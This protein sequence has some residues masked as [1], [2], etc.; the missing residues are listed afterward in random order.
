MSPNKVLSYGAF[1]FAL[2]KGYCNEKRA[3]LQVAVPEYVNQ[4]IAPG[5]IWFKYRS[6]QREAEAAAKALEK[7]KAEQA[8]VSAA[9]TENTNTQ[10]PAKV[11]ETV[12]ESNSESQE[13]ATTYF[14]QLDSVPTQTD[15]VTALLTYIIGGSIPKD[16]IIKNYMTTLPSVI[17]TNLTEAEA[18]TIITQLNAT[19]A[20][21][22]KHA[23]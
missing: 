2:F 14:V 20:R 15:R 21:A 3:P 5:A 10:E 8:K 11:S 23:E 4:A 7:E 6:K 13:K 9:T 12:A 1:S 16:M 19:G 17:K 22:S 18:E